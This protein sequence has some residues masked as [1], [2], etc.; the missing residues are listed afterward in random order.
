MKRL[1]ACLFLMV[2]L[3]PALSNDRAQSSLPFGGSVAMAG[4]SMPGGR[5]CDCD[6]TACLNALKIEP[7][8]EPAPESAEVDTGSVAALA[9]AAVLLVL[10]LRQLV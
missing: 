7:A 3:L 5:W 4:H 10:R 6:G 1:I 9:V 8:P 2:C